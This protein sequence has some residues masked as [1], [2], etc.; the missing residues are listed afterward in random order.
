MQ[1]T[2]KG[3]ITIPSEFRIK[4]GLLPH[5]EVKFIEADGK[6]CLIKAKHAKKESRGQ[7]IIQRMQSVPINKTMSTDEILALTRGYG[8]DEK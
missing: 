6:L 8:I 3:Q 2:I 1:V 5:T 7:R 4:Y